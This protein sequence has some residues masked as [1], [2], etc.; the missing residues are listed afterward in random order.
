MER[1]HVVVGLPAVDL[2][3]RPAKSLTNQLIVAGQ[4]RTA[5]NLGHHGFRVVLG[6]QLGVGERLHGEAA[7]VFIRQRLLCLKP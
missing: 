7:M 1:G 4:G 2:L 5:A 3:A 6:V